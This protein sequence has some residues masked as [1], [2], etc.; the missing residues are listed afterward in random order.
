MPSSLRLLLLAL[1][2]IL[3]A[4]GLADPARAKPK[5]DT[6]RRPVRAVAA[7][8]IEIA[9]E[10]GRGVLPI[11]VS[12]DWT[13]PLPGV[14]RAVVVLHGR[15]RNAETYGRLVEAMLAEGG[16]PAAAETLVVAPQF[17]APVDL[18]GHGLPAETL[19]WASGSWQAGGDA[20]DPAPV[21]SFE[22]LDAVMARLADRALLPDLATVVIAGHSGGAQLA[23]RYTAAGR[24][25]A[26]IEAAGLRLRFVV[27]NPASYLYFDAERPDGRGGY[28]VPAAEACPG[29]DSWRYGMRDLPRYLRG[30]A[31]QAIEA[32]YAAR[33]VT[34]LLGTEDRDP[35]HHSLDRS[36]AAMAQGPHRLARG[37]AYFRHLSAR[38]PGLA[39]HRLVEVP[40]VGH[41]P[42]AM[43][44]S[45]CGRAALLDRPGCE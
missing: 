36:C 24:A 42:R 19:R 21:S 29:Y 34:Y 6:G 15:V 4:C 2:A 16:R 9:T 41:D 28:A 25:L 38:H 13:R 37:W 39:G 17:L 18:A 44:S 26:A 8:R 40:G 22:A 31:A 30:Q 11:H 27:A 45:A 35:A 20:L 43:L 14:R 3:V 1:A 5:E 10:D 33:E 12:A 23:Q 32:R 7:E